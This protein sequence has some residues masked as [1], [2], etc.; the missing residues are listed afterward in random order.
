MVISKLE[1]TYRKAR[2]DSHRNTSLDVA[3]TETNVRNCLPLDFFLQEKNKP[4]LLE[5][6]K[7]GFQSLAVKHTSNRG[8]T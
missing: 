8:P 4:L 2:Q 5:L 7:L 3:E 6:Q 1:L